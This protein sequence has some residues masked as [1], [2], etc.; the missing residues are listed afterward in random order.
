ME[1][2]SATTRWYSSKEVCPRTCLTKYFAASFGF[3]TPATSL[4]TKQQKNAPIPVAVQFGK[5]VLSDIYALPRS[6]G[7]STQLPGRLLGLNS[8]LCLRYLQ[9]DFRQQRS[10]SQSVNQGWGVPTYLI[11]SKPPVLPNGLI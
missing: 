7:C 9:T 6:T 2:V 10:A 1:R 3:G 5:H 11:G 8:W 4:R